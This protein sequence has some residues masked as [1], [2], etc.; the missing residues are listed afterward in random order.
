[1]VY[2]KVCMLWSLCSAI[3]IGNVVGF[4][5][6]ERI[7]G[8]EIIP[9]EAAPYTVLLWHRRP[10]INHTAG[11]GALIEVDGVQAV[12]TSAAQVMEQFDEDDKGVDPAPLLS[13]YVGL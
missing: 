11:T 10:S 5:G 12:L 13:V 7:I 6:R 9:I 1:M 3:R 4:Y 8:G 2:L